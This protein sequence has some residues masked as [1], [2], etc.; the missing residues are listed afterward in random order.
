MKNMQNFAAQRLTKRQ[1]NHVYGGANVVVACDVLDLNDKKIATVKG[2][3]ATLND[4]WL[5]A[6]NNASG[7]KV[8]NCK[9]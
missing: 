2:E 6:A 1:M 4:A 7:Y 3:G 8:A 9:S 5:D